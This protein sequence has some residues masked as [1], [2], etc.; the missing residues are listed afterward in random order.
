MFFPSTQKIT[1]I[2]SKVDYNLESRKDSKMNDNRNGKTRVVEVIG[3]LIIACLIFIFGLYAGRVQEAR[4]NLQ[5]TDARFEQALEESAKQTQRYKEPY[6]L[7]TYS[8]EEVMIPLIGDEENWVVINLLIKIES[9]GDPC[10]ISPAGAR[11]L[12]QIMKPT[13]Q[14]CEE[15]L[16]VD[17]DWDN[18]WYVTA[19][20]RAFGIY[21]VNNRI[22][23]MLRHY[24]IPDSVNTRL[25]CY[26]WGIGHVKRAIREHGSEWQS[27]MPEETK[28]YI[29]K[30]HKLK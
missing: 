2:I 3:A 19:K 30:Y 24:H 17:W 12:C 29:R 15:L 27:Q 8:G 23:K 6:Y 10:A 9:G 13:W 26:N 4:R 11:G 16:E 20:N 28:N 25:A 1:C 14:E 5:K 21:Y 7:H 18:N 22:P